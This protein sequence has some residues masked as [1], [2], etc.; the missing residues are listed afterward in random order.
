MDTRIVSQ[1]V[2]DKVLGQVRKGQETMAGA[3]RAA[4][5]V[6]QSVTPPGPALPP[7]LASRLPSRDELVSSAHDLAGQL[8]AVQRKATVL[9][10]TRRVASDLQTI[11]R[12]ANEILDAQ[13]KLADRAIDAVS[14]LL[15]RAGITT[16]HPTH[17]PAGI[18][19]QP[20]PSTVTDD[21]AGASSVS[22]SKI[23]RLPK[24]ATAEARASKARQPRKAAAT[25][26]GST[27]AGTGTGTGTKPAGTKPAAAKKS[28]TKA[29]TTKPAGTIKPEGTDKK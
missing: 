15:A 8:L 22:V 11:Q 2:Q 24:T 7:A 18:F 5:A 6:A 3:L 27:K 19:G 29:S 21:P 17:A 20:A 9:L 25:K 4:A 14:P 16:A 12:K 28:T 13:R 26:A 23:S 1:E 10:D